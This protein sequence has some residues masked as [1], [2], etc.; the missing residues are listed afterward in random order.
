[1]QINAVKPASRTLLPVIENGTVLRKLSNGRNQDGAWKSQ[2]KREKRGQVR[3]PGD[4]LRQ[5]VWKLCQPV[6][7]IDTVV[8]Y[9]AKYSVTF[10]EIH[11]IKNLNIV[12]LSILWCLDFLWL[13]IFF[14]VEYFFNCEDNTWVFLLPKTSIT[15]FL[16]S[17]IAVHLFIYSSHYSTTIS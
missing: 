3:E 17:V 2:A 8:L 5:G 12:N 16:C 11:N 15:C 4:R 9:S 6:W 13:Y 14:T 1:M 7:W 10:L